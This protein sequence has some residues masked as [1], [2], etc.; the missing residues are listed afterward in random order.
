MG[1][2]L[3]P[4]MIVIGLI[5]G[6]AGAYFA[7]PIIRPAYVEEL[8]TRL[9]SLNAPPDTS[10]VQV[11]Q[12]MPTDPDQGVSDEDSLNELRQELELVKREAEILAGH[13]NRLTSRIDSVLGQE[14]AVTQLAGTLSAMEDKELEELVASLDEKV[15][16]AVYSASNRKNQARLLSKIPPEQAARVIQALFDERKH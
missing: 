3:T 16:I 14:A 5:L 13:N 10:T 1:K 15:L 6:F 2:L 9:D 11:D 4:L 8:Q 7:M 12:S